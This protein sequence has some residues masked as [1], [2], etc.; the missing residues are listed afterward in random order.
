MVTTTLRF[1]ANA[2]RARLR[3]AIRRYDDRAA[4]PHIRLRR[5]GSSPMVVVGVVILVAIAALFLVGDRRR[6]T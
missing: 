4:G 3:A 6:R 1:E 5:S 2:R